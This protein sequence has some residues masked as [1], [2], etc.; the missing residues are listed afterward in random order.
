MFIFQPTQLNAT[1]KEIPFENIL[2]KRKNTV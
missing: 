2:K 1:N